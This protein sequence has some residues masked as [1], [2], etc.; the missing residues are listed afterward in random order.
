MTLY[1]A[2]NKTNDNKQDKLIRLCL[3]IAIYTSSFDIVGIVNLFGFN[4]RLT[5][6]AILPLLIHMAFLSLRKEKIIMPK[7]MIFLIL[8]VVLQTL[9]SFRSPSLKNA[10]GYDLWLIFDVFVVFSVVFFLDKSY[11]FK[12]L[13][14]TYINSFEFMAVIGLVQMFLFSIGINFFVEQ[15]W[16]DRLARINGFSYEPSYYATYLVMGYVLCSYLVLKKNEELFECK[17]LRRKQILI[18]LA[19]FLSSSRM[20]WIMIALWIMIKIIISV[21]QLFT[22]EINKSSVIVASAAPMFLCLIYILAERILKKFDFSF[23][24]NGTGLA[25]KA[26]HSTEHRMESLQNCIDIFRENPFLGY[27]LGGVDPI[28]SLK[29]GHVYS[30]L[31]N[32]QGSTIGEILVASGLI[33]TVLLILYFI[34]LCVTK[35]KNPIHLSL[36][37]SLIFELLILC[38]NQNILRPY[39]WMHIAVLSASFRNWGLQGKILREGINGKNI[40]DRKSAFSNN[41]CCSNKKNFIK[42]AKS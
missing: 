23:L 32:G 5:Q 35:N 39:V 19:L 3:A 1:S 11:D 24:L 4:F 14:R 38:M 8:W 9:F 34:K 12:W 22:S 17:S 33:G 6:L 25:G 7:G 31:D 27:G 29:A 13:M 18:T 42:R 26:S 36:V 16:N 30:T 15:N 41:G 10:V 40:D 21:Y 20:G 2:E 28:L 37:I